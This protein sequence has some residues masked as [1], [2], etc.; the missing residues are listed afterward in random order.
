MKGT[1][2]RSTL[3]EVGA[4]LHREL[5]VTLTRPPRPDRW[6]FVVGCYNSGTELLMNVLG[7]HPEIGALPTEGQFLT[8]QLVADYELG[9]HRMWVLREDFFRL[10]EA[11]PG[12]DALRMKK[13]WGLRLDRSCPVL[14][15]KSPPNTARTRWLQHHFENAH[16]IAMVRNGYA[17]AE[18]IRRKARPK[19]LRE[20]WPIEQC[21]RQ[22]NRCYEVLLEDAGHL[23]RL[24]WLKYEDL[25][26]DPHRELERVL[27]FLGLAGSREVDPGAHWRVHERN[28]PIRDMNPESIGRLTADDID[29]IRRVAA[30]MLRHFGYPDPA[31]PAPT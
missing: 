20:G 14:L 10:T 13:E 23:A 19:H 18:G 27:D 30:P 21:A 22:W 16:F 4:R 8:D 1:R 11:D 15:E 12:P 7:A 9:L 28:E 31:R 3:R 29:T 24:Q 25:V 6:V 26:E 2:W 5:R 17:V